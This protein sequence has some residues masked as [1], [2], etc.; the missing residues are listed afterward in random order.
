MDGEL[1]AFHGGDLLRRFRLGAE[2]HGGDNRVH[3]VLLKF[4]IGA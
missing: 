3:R 4:R 2:R 1:V